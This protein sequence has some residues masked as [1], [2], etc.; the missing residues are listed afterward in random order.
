MVTAGGNEC[1][2]IAIALHQFEAKDTAVEAKRA[3]E[4][5]DFQVDMSDPGAGDDRVWI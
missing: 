4:V 1:S 5:G 2:L 3:L